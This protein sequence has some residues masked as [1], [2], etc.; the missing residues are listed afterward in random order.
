MGLLD[1]LFPGISEKKK[2]EM[3]SA[4]ENWDFASDSGPSSGNDFASNAKSKILEETKRNRE[5]SGDKQA[6]TKEAISDTQTNA[7]TE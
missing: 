4:I 2:K 6:K 3:I 5:A 1:K 7:V